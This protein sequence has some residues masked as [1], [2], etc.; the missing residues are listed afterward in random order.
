MPGKPNKHWTV[1]TVVIPRIASIVQKLGNLAVDLQTIYISVDFT[2][3]RASL[4]GEQRT[5]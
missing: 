2:R 5:F 4:P 1:G 3:E